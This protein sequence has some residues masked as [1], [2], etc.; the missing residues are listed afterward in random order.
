MQVQY[1]ASW[2][3][4]GCDGDLAP[5]VAGGAVLPYSVWACPACLYANWSGAFEKGV[6]EETKVHIRRRSPDKPEA[7]STCRKYE[8]AAR[9]A[10]WE[11]APAGEQGTILLNGAWAVR[12]ECRNAVGALAPNP[13]L[14]KRFE[15]ALEAAGARVRNLP[16][17]AGEALIARLVRSE[18][19]AASAERAAADARAVGK[20]DAILDLAA[21]FLHRRT[22]ENDAAKR[23]LAGT[24]V[25]D[26]PPEIRAAIDALEVSMV[27][28]GNLQL[29]ALPLLL[30]VARAAEGVPEARAWARIAV[31]D[32]LRRLGRGE[33]AAPLFLVEAKD[34]EAP[35]WAVALC[36]HGLARI[37]AGREV[38]AALDAA[39]ARAREA[40]RKRLLDPEAAEGAARLIGDSG[41][42]GFFPD[43]VAALGNGDADVRAAALVALHR[44]DAFDLPPAALEA[45]GRM[46]LDPKEKQRTRESACRR[47]AEEAA[48][49]SLPVF[50]AGLDDPSSDIRGCALSG[51]ARGGEAQDVPALLA[52]VARGKDAIQW[53]ERRDALRALTCLA[54]AEIPDPEAAAKWW[55]SA[56]GRPREAWVLDGFR[57]AGTEVKGPLAR[58]SIPAL[59]ALL[60]AEPPWARWNAHRALRAL[61]GRRF[62]WDRRT[63]VWN[64]GPRT[65]E[66]E[67]PA[68]VEEWRAWWAAEPPR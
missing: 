63:D 3:S 33:E 2:T 50:R 8:L 6:T 25:P 18:A 46:A 59:L 62:G 13:A 15:E 56:K 55:A 31:A 12:Q 5:R 45:L 17:P 9:V 48:P 44:M 1:I 52:F 27:Q 39:E 67:R 16:L 36:R 47:L 58:E 22:G 30:D 19:A 53:F 64:S 28:E 29:S 40:L 37:G 54:N 57:A 43:L 61:T 26:V 34:A 23:L 32:T 41:D 7:L 24:K 35:A 14:E 4:D 65:P 49:A 60:D 51:L 42:I 66:K 21:A 68:W 20:P 38:M 10:E 11:G